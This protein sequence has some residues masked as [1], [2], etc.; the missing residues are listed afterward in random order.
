MS[1]HAL[2]PWRPYPERSDEEQIA[3][4]HAFAERMATRRSCRD[5]S[6]R[7]VPRGTIEAALRAAGTA[8]SGANR[9]PWH[10]CVLSSPEVKA[11]IRVAVEEE[12]R[13]FYGG[14][15]GRDWL[16]AVRPLATAPEKPFLETAPWLIA[17]FAQNRSLEGEDLQPNYNVAESVGIACGLLLASLHEAGLASL[18]HTP[19]PMHF[20]NRVCRRPPTETP[21]M[22]IVVGH[23][24]DDATIPATVAKGRKSL[25]QIASW[26]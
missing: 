2:V 11:T 4:A 24:A 15:A 1:M 17:V 25:E 7:P 8:P 6:D 9:Q 23:A 3:L 14:R 18:V 22:L 19:H 13:Q 5:F 10:F 20:L 16:S 21:M 26:L 12:E